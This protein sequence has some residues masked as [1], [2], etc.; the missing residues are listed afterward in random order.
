MSGSNGISRRSA[1]KS[2]FACG[3]I[4]LLPAR[5][6]DGSIAATV[7]AGNTGHPISNL[8][9]GEF[10]EHG[11]NLINYSLWSEV[12]DDRKFFHPVD[13]R[14]LPPVTIRRGPPMMTVA[15]KWNP[16]GPDADVAMDKTAPYVG[17]Q[18]PVVRLAGSAPR[19]IAQDGL[20]LARKDYAEPF[21]IELYRFGA[22]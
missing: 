9:F 12:L 8:M 15:R 13:S 5:A 6:A 11:G 17:E 4:S 1:V 3:L 22:A 10:L 16:I 21:A 18:S 2:S 20:S 19:G 14:P 7:N